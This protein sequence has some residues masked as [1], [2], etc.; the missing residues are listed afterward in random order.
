MVLG[1]LEG[2]PDAALAIIA[3]VIIAPAITRAFIVA[4]APIVVMDAKAPGGAIVVTLMHTPAIA[5]AVADHIS[6]RRRRSGN[7]GSRTGKRPQYKSP[8]LQR[9]SPSLSEPPPGVANGGTLQPLRSLLTV[10]AGSLARP[11]PASCAR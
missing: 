11:I 7:Q 1:P 2:D 3:A 8:D 6:G 10:A 9:S 5:I 4:P